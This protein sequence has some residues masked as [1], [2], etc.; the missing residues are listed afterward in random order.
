MGRQQENVKV[1]PIQRLIMPLITNVL[2]AQPVAELT[3]IKMDATVMTQINIG[4]QPAPKSVNVQT[5]QVHQSLK[6]V[7]YALHVLVNLVLQP[8]N[9]LVKPLEKS[10][11]IVYRAQLITKYKRRVR[12]RKTAKILFVYQVIVLSRQRR[13]VSQTNVLVNLVR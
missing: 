1:V 2:N 10:V 3:A 12:K 4:K 5:V 7:D 9:L 13:N 11:V 6:T 8:K